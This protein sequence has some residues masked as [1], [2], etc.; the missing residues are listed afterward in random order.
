MKNLGNLAG[1][2]GDAKEVRKSLIEKN[3]KPKPN[4]MTINKPGTESG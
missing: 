2:G 3:L 1:Q 4:G